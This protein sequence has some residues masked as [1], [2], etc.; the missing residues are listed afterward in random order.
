ME[1]QNQIK[2][3]IDAWLVVSPIVTPLHPEA[4]FISALK[5]LTEIATRLPG[6]KLMHSQTRLILSSKVALKLDGVP[7]ALSVPTCP[8]CEIEME[9][10]RSKFG[11]FFGCP[12][13]PGCN[14]KVKLAD[15]LVLKSMA[16]LQSKGMV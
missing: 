7:V 16:S 9:L 14:E 4:N 10:R 6:F 13:Y 8:E 5:C 15:Q 2:L 12:N 11:A 1:A 3:D